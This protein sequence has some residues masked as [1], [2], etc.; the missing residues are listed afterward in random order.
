AI[1]SASSGEFQMIEDEVLTIVNGTGNRAEELNSLV[2]QFRRGRE[3]EDLLR[4]LCSDNN[5]LVRTGAYIASEISIEQYNSTSFI[6]RLRELTDH[7]IPLIRCFALTALYPFLDATQ[8]ETRDLI[9]KLLKDTNE[10]VRMSAEAAA[11]SLGI[12]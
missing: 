5:E 2:D 6:G 1:A 7:Q 11:R 8:Q 12:E 9:A 4:L 10:G 3:P